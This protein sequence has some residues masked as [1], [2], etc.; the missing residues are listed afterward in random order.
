MRTT[1]GTAAA[2]A[3]WMTL[4]PVIAMAA[5]GPTAPYNEAVRIV[6]GQRV[7][8][9][10]PIPAHVMKTMVWM[11]PGEKGLEHIRIAVETQLG[12]MDCH[13][14]NGYDPRACVPSTFGKVRT[15]RQWVVKMKGQWRLCA[16]REKPI[17]CVGLTDPPYLPVVEE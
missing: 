10:P 2:L 14:L 3:A 8:E 16:G 12:L 1:M 5:D 9:L 17:K 15:S 11:K 6:N 13:Q 7:V 4:G